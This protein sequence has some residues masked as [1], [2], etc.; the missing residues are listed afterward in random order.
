M[1]KN[2]LT[3]APFMSLAPATIG[4]VRKD[5]REKTGAKEKERATRAF[6]MSEEEFSSDLARM[7]TGE[8]L[9]RVK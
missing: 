4:K 8:Y 2:S 1:N 3:F 6:S 5:H 7:F 9:P